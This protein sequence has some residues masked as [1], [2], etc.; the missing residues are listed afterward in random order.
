MIKIVRLAALAAVATAAATPAGAQVSANPPARA[1]VNVTK[2]LILEAEE[3]LQF[4]SVAVYGPGTITVPA[5]NS[6]PTCGPVAEM[7]CDF[8]GAQRAEYTVRGAN[9]AIVTVN[10][11]PS[12]L[13]G[14]VSGDT[15]AFRPL[16]QATL[17]LNNSG[18]AG[19]TLYVGGE[20]DVDETTA[21]DSYSGDIEVTVEY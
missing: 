7:T 3:D 5:D 11:T 14:L 4:G 2:P 12:T 20:V 15:V 21:E 10:V 18:S 17:Q 1:H 6:A 19:T 16:A 9:N 8:T 13:D